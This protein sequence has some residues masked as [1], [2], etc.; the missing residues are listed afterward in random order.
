MSVWQTPQAASRTSTSPGPGPSRSTSCTTS[1]LANSSRTAARTFTRRTLSRNARALRRN[2]R[3][4]HDRPMP[5]ETNLVL[6]S[7]AQL[8]SH[9]RDAEIAAL[10]ARQH[11]VVAHRQLIRLGL[12]RNAIQYRL[13]V[14]RL[15]SLHRGVYAVG[16]TKI[17]ST[18]RDMAAVLAC[19]P[20]AVLS[21]RA[22]GALWGLRPSSAAR[23]D[24]TTPR[25]LGRRHGIRLHVS[26]VPTD[27]RTVLHGV[28]VTTVP[29]TMF[30]LAA[31]L[32]PHDLERM[33][34]QAAVL[35]LTDPLSLPAVLKRYPGYRGAA[36][37][38]AALR[39]RKPRPGHHAERARGPLPEAGEEGPLPAA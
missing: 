32:R 2:T 39:I 13:R 22:A 26:R 16:H 7:S 35:Q 14:G 5:G 31:E 27:E 17:S 34:D 28:P 36:S 25:Q 1:G 3:R 15:H 19:G 33:I 37:L 23:I 24:V 10:A 18:G 9:A 20:G 29:R 21:H 6:N 12:D 11:G 38:G 30:D 4:P 8:S